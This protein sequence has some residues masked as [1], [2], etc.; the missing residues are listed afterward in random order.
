[1]VGA[2]PDFRH[3]YLSDM[4]AQFAKLRNTAERAMAQV[5]DEDFVKV[6]CGLGALIF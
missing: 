3:E 4:R 6:L 2:T 5:R 1:V